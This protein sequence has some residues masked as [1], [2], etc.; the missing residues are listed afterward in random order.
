[1]P[2]VMFFADDTLIG[3]KSLTKI[4]QLLQ[5]AL[6]EAI[7]WFRQNNSTLNIYKCNVLIISNTN[8]VD[9]IDTFLN[10]AKLPFVKSVESLG[11]KI[12]NKLSCSN[13]VNVD[14]LCTCKS[15]KRNTAISSLY[16]S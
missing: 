6:N 7:K 15:K 10:G 13:H 11:V 12:D 1:M 4:Q 8:I 14:G 3:D 9:S 16:L 5:N 2:S